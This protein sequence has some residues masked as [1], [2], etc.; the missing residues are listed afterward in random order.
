M[1]KKCEQAFIDRKKKSQI[2]Q[3]KIA[4][5]DNGLF[6]TMLDTGWSQTVW[7][8]YPTWC[9]QLRQHF[10]F[11]GPCVVLEDVQHLPTFINTIHI[12][13]HLTCKCLLVSGHVN[14]VKLYS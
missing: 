4:V 1:I 7:C 13:F 5:S 6:L 9:C 3:V 14:E 8:G 2:S 12:A 11:P 10:C